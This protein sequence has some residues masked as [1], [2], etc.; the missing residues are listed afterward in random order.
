MTDDDVLHA[1]LRAR[2]DRTPCA[3]VTVAATTGSV[4]RAPGAKMLVHAD[5]TIVGTIGGGKFESLVIG[6]CTAALATKSPLLRL[7]LARSRCRIVR[8][9]LRRREVTVFIEPQSTREAIFL[10]GAWHCARAIADLAR[11]ATGMSP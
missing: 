6:D 11:I 2:E 4:P 5:G 7:S 10:V 1:L 9:D 3:L 8:S